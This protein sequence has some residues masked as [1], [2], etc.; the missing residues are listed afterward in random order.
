MKVRAERIIAEMLREIA[1]SLLKRISHSIGLQELEETYK[2]VSDLRDH[3]LSS[4]LIDLS[5][6]LDN[7]L[8]AGERLGKFLA[9]AAAD[10]LD[11]RHHARCALEIED[12]IL[13]LLVDHIAVTDHD[14][15]IEDLLVLGVMQ[16]GE[17][18][19]SPGNLIR[20]A[21]TCGMLD[22][23]LAARTLGLYGIQQLPCCVELVVTREEIPGQLLLVVLFGDEVAAQDV[24]E[25][26]AFPY[27]FPQIAR[28]MAGRR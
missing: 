7:L 24:E 3:C 20:L 23:V 18:M 28:A 1:F 26:L 25:A 8:I 5:I 9:L 13:Q 27:F 21:R 22:Q 17:E 4:R 6:H 19:G 14:H 12:R 15:R 11:A 16:V 10:A 2:E